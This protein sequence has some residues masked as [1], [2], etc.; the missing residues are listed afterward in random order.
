MNNTSVGTTF[1]LITVVVPVYNVEDY[2]EDCV[3]SLLG[4]DYPNLEIVLVDDGSSDTS[5]FI[6]DRLGLDNDRVAVYHKENGGLSD[7]RN[8]GLARSHGEW[9]AFV[10]SDDYVSPLFV[11]TLYSA[12]HDT[13]CASA[14]VTGW[15]SFHDGEEVRLLGENCPVAPVPAG[16]PWR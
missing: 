4:Q 8:Y 6:C 5:G 1:P 12:A 9:I 13:G 2:V 7:A 11:S 10:D 3:Q 14:A 16:H 15:R